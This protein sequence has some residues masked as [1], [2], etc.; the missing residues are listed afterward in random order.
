L[1][2]S[3]CRNLRTK[4]IFKAMQNDRNRGITIVMRHFRGFFLDPDRALV[5]RGGTSGTIWI[6]QLHIMKLQESVNRGS[7]RRRCRRSCG[8]FLRPS[9]CAELL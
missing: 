3:L 8:P 5:V 2:L 7:R 9:L 4:T 6:Q 1:D